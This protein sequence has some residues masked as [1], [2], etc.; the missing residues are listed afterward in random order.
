[1][2]SSPPAPTSVEVRRQLAS[3]ALSPDEQL[4]PTAAVTTSLTPSVDQEAVAGVEMPPQSP[5]VQLDGFSEVLIEPAAAAATPDCLP[6]DF[7]PSAS[8]PEPA[9]LDTTAATTAH[10]SPAISP[11]GAAIPIAQPVPSPPARAS[12]SV[13]VA[14]PPAAAPAGAAS[15]A[16]SYPLANDPAPIAAVQAV[17][18]NL[19]AKFEGWFNRASTKVGAPGLPD[20]SAASAALASS[21]THSAAGASTVAAPVPALATAPDSV[22]AA[23]LVAE[24]TLGGV[25]TPWLHSI[26][27]YGVNKVLGMDDT[28]DGMEEQW[29]TVLCRESLWLPADMDLQHGEAAT[30]SSSSAAA[31]A[32][33]EAA[34]APPPLLLEMSH[35]YPKGF[36]STPLPVI[37]VRTPYDRALMRHSA[38]RIAQHGY[39]V[40]VQDTRNS[41]NAAA[42]K[43]KQHLKQRAMKK[44]AAVSAL[45]AGAAAQTAGD[46]AATA[47]AT[48]AAAAGAGE[49]SSATHSRTSSGENGESSAAV[50]DSSSGGASHPKLHCAPAEFFPVVH[51]SADGL[52]TIQWAVQQPWCDGNISFFGLSYLGIAQYSVVDHQHPAVK[53][54][55]PVVSASR[56]YE[57]LCPQ[58]SFALDLAARWLYVMFHPNAVGTGAGG[59][60]GGGVGGGEEE[61]PADAKLPS[62]WR[63]SL[64]RV[65]GQRTVVPHALA[66]LPGC[67]LD[68]K[69]AARQ[70]SFFQEM[71][72]HAGKPESPFWKQKRVQLCDLANSPPLLI[73]EGWYDIFLREALR[74]YCDALAIWKAHQADVAAGRVSAEAEAKAGSASRR[75]S[76]P[77]LTIINCV[78]IDWRQLLRISLAE[79]I[80]WFD[81]HLKPHSAQAAKR[82]AERPEDKSVRVQLINASAG[83]ESRHL[84]LIARRKK[85]EAKAEAAR[86]ALVANA[87]VAAVPAVDLAE[88]ARA[89]ERQAFLD[90]EWLS[91]PEFPPPGVKEVRWYLHCELDEQGEERR[92][93]RTDAPGERERN[94]AAAMQL[95]ADKQRRIDE[96]HSNEDVAVRQLVARMVD[97][98]IAAAVANAST[99]PPSPDTIAVPVVPPPKTPSPMQQS[100]ANAFAF[101]KD[102]SAKASD[103]LAASASSMA[104]A[105]STATVAPA[106][107]VLITAKTFADATLPPLPPARSHWSRYTYDPA[108]PTPAIG[109]ATFDVENCGALDQRS[110][111]ARSDVLVFTSEPLEEALLVLGFVR[112]ELYVRT[113]AF[114]TDFV[115][116]LCD[117]YPLDDWASSADWKAGH[118]KSQVL[119]DGMFKVTPVQ[120]AELTVEQQPGSGAALA[121]SKP[122]AFS[123]A[124]QKE[125]AA[126]S[127]AGEAPMPDADTPLLKLHIDM[128]ATGNVFQRGHRIRFTV[129]SAAHPRWLRCLGGADPMF[130]SLDAAVLQHQTV[131]HDAACP[132]ALVLPVLPA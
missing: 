50:A 56:V 127:A 37:I 1:M 57:I 23:A 70:L 110:C 104:S 7:P 25:S 132:S 44:A 46:A 55:A 21:K 122:R 24:D 45:A 28:E 72:Q 49:P 129:C 12:R 26:V 97:E 32:A 61:D 35:Y 19:G 101:V 74:D 90:S 66:H 114:V 88:A 119:C 69:V 58:G 75:N 20:T 84:G 11:S 30:A 111:E 16:S 62:F 17:F 5:N 40:L 95:L 78:H 42:L 105:V 52:A 77:Y 98:V 68:E 89:K 92:V 65:V 112:C 47:A 107:P 123:E 82:R 48:P 99:A 9:A 43:A 22:S 131:Y 63:R 73:V 108:Q 31:G 102:L 41:P 120:M 125:A 115:G 80:K 2:S 4:S 60:L 86:A 87:S 130:H 8:P 59:G 117:V 64:A 14:A 27:R 67:E 128:W 85:A 100:M 13:S 15:S 121:A 6:V 109:G 124:G 113:S 118:G 93:L 106:A 51:E 29:K 33:A 10:S 83:N 38:E 103:A 126:A 116:R 18:T 34:D 54:L 94:Y 36:H 91:F 81:M 79:S 53:C 76:K 71:V 3:I 96:Q 39:H